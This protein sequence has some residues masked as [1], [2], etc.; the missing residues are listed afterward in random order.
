MPVLPI[1]FYTRAKLV[2][3]RVKG[4][5]TTPLDNFPWKYADLAP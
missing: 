3:P 5:R 2:N 1:F 4:Y